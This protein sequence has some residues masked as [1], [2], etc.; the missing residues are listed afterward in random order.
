MKKNIILL[1]NT[2]GNG[3]AQRQ[4]ILLAQELSNLGCT[5]CLMHYGLSEEMLDNFDVSGFDV[6]RI[7]N[8]HGLI[9][10]YI[11]LF[12]RMRSF[13]PVAVISFIE[14]PNII[15]GMYSVFNPAVKWLPCE[16]NLSSA[17]E[18]L[19]IF[20]RNLL[21]WRANFIISNSFS[22]KKWIDEKVWRASNKSLTVLNGVPDT[23]FAPPN[24]NFIMRKK[25][26]LS[27]AR[28]SIQKN[29]ELLIDA[30]VTNKNI[31]H[32]G[33]HFEW[34]GDDDP[35][36]LNKRALLSKKI[37]FNELPINIFYAT[38]DVKA[39]M[40]QAKFLILTSL[41]EG[42]PNVVL[43]A[44][45]SGMVVIASK[46]SD[47]PYILGDGRGILFES[48]SVDG[49]SLAI[50]SAIGMNDNDIEK[51]VERSRK[52]ALENFSKSVM[53]KKYHSLIN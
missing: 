8:E 51:I 44:M 20:W 36:D 35:S 30:L 21:Y 42:T 47:L 2:L 41:Y 5:V 27:F 7:P 11:E 6:V 3:G 28:L 46:V 29:P 43:E 45:I 24:G 1:I 50:E 17:N 14:V 53:S 40:N 22:Q 23:F 19:G 18:F 37:E 38:K 48:N 33:W 26:F 25:L 4:I 49:L 31:C 52:F 12:R 32:S 15:A 39:K 34:Y 13:D 16:R 10:K 9:N